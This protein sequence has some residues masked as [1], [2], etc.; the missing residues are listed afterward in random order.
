MPFETDQLPEYA[1]LDVQFIEDRKHHVL[2]GVFQ[3]ADAHYSFANA[4]QRFEAES[5]SNQQ[6]GNPQNEWTPQV[7]S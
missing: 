2:R 1:E 3:I 4:M 6:A 5:Y 7:Q